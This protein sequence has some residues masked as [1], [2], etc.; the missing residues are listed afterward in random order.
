LKVAFQGVRGAY[1]EAA[2]K[3]HIGE[4]VT[5]VPC[6]SFRDVFEAVETGKVDLGCI[7]IE[8]S[9]T[10]S[11]HQNFDLL[12]TQNLWIVGETQI[13]VIHNFIVNKG[14]TLNEIKMVYSHPQGLQ[15]CE[16]FLSQFPQIEQV[17][18]YD[19]AGSVKMIKEKKILN[20][21]AIASSEAAEYYD[22]DILQKGIEDVR[23]NYTRFYFLSREKKMAPDANK[24]SIVF[25]TRNVPGIL[26]KSLSVFALRDIGLSKIESRPVHGKP[27]EYYFY[28]DIE[29][30]I[31]HEACKNA[32]NHLKEIATY[33]K[34]LGCFKDGLSRD[35]DNI[36]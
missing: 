21:A 25:A 13:R 23:E 5:V 27:W 16:N 15:Q 24:T 10:G 36:L 7:P 29:D 34:I 28:L 2:V 17:P 18:T 1:S 32:I 14:I 6:H 4:L 35:D 8:N 26:F 19:T 9:R 11:I 20:A 3:K 22:M 31:E 33:T 30:N 12:L